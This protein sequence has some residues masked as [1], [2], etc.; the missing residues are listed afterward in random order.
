VVE[1][2]KRALDV[3]AEGMK[4]LLC[5]DNSSRRQHKH[6][7]RVHATSANCQHVGWARG[8]WDWRVVN[9]RYKH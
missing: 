8:H 1:S 7:V 5:S 2:N 9:S 4:R 6:W 3:V